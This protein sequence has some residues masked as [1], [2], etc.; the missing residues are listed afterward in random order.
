MKIF[1]LSVPTEESP[2][3]PLPIRVEHQAHED[4]A[5]LMINFF[6]ATIDDLPNG[7]G[8]ANDN[9]YMNAHS[10]THV[11]APWHYYP[12]CRGTRA[13][14]I[15]ELPLEW[16]F[17]DGVVVDM[18]HKSKGGLIDTE[19]VQTSLQNMN[20]ALKPG[21]IVLIQT[22][23]DKYWGQAEYFEAGAGMSAT[24]TRWLI[25]QGI[26][27]MGIDTWGW[28]QPFWAMKERFKETKDPGVIWEAHRV[29]IDLEYCQIEKLA[30]L[31]K[32]PRPYGFKVA[33][34]PVKLTGGSGGWSR[35]VAIFDDL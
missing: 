5:E 22:G 30:N 4:S 16:F 3:E 9:V 15:D 28:D 14:T 27:V 33:C 35:V 11:D 24:A 21:D 10:G 26:R 34:F 18:R 29:G 8:W 23:A 32:L 25:D 17:G 31:E 19:D 12:T 13:R 7:L 1:D 2:S 6:D 20:Y